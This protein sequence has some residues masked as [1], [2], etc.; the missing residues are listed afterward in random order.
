MCTGGEVLAEIVAPD[1]RSRRV[2][3]WLYWVVLL[4]VLAF[5]VYLVLETGTLG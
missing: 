5:G 2:V 1:S 4:G 3:R